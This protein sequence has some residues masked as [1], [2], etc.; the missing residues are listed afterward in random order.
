[1][2]KRGGFLTGDLV[3]GWSCRWELCMCVFL[4]GD[5]V[6]GRSTQVG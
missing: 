2:C 3:S 1:M 5:L 4:T 6:L